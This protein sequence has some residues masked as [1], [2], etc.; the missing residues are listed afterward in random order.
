[1][2]NDYTIFFGGEKIMWTCS[3]LKTNAKSTLKNYYWWAFLVCLVAGL[4]GGGGGGGGSSS[5]GGASAP[6]GTGEIFSEDAS[7]A[8]LIGYLVVMVALV[9]LVFL[10]AL[11]VGFAISAFL[12]NVVMCGK[13]RFFMR[14]RLGKVDFSNLFWSFSGGR[15]MKTVVPL[16][17]VTLYTFLWSL[18]F[19]IPGII[20]S[21]EY[22]MVPYIIA[23]NPNIPTERAFEISKQ[24]MN[25]EKFNRWVLELSFIGWYLLSVFTFGIGIL[26]LNPYLEATR[27]EF[28]E[29]A[30]EKALASGIARPDELIGF[31]D[32]IVEERVI[33]TG[34][35]Y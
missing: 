23:E 21:Y 34:E 1:M 26:F 20:K 19:V 33:S 18:L 8:E 5:G 12:G 32:T 11:A 25:G 16:F 3:Q 14:A 13:C 10:I 22:I 17:K 6:A 31:E 9:I 30:R 15:Y 29:Y 27:A 24:T 35:Q 7:T 4:L 2:Y 28:Y